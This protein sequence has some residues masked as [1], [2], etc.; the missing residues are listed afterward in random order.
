MITSNTLPYEKT[1]TW[2][3]FYSILTLALLLKVQTI[4]AQ[5][6]TGKSYINVTKGLS[7]GTFE[8]GDTLEIRAAIAV[9]NSNTITSVRYNDSIDNNFTYIPASLKILTNEGLTF[10]AY[11]DAAR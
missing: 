3:D 8:P 11:S 10:R 2:Y 5:V 7:G 4:L 1:F 9:G 6:Q